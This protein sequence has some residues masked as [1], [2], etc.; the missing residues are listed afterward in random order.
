MRKI[1]LFAIVVVSLYSDWFNDIYREIFGVEDCSTMQSR[2]F[3]KSWQPFLENSEDAIKL[4]NQIDKTDIEDSWIPFIDT[5]ERLR[6]DFNSILDDIISILSQDTKV[7][8]CLKELQNINRKI[9]EEKEE[10]LRLKEKDISEVNQEIKEQV[11]EKFREIEALQKEMK[12]VRKS[13][14]AE[15]Q[16]LGLN[17]KPEELEAL[18]IRV[19]SF[20]IVQMLVVFD[21]SKKIVD[22]LGKLMESNSSN[23]RVI[24]RYYGMNLIVSEI[25][26][27]IQT[28][29]IEE[30]DRKYIPKLKKV[31]SRVEKL[32]SETKK[33]LK[34]SSSDYE[35]EI[36]QK[37]L[38]SQRL[39]IKTAKLYIEN[40]QSQRR[41]IEEAQK[42]SL[43]NLNL[44]RNSYR[45][46]EAGTALLNLI[47][48]SKENFNKIINLQIPKIIPFDNQAIAKEYQRLTDEIRK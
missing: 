2:N 19:D 8:E 6:R 5:K 12:I 23:M 31:I 7:I 11:A 1:F 33:L 22:R 20:N 24:K 25:A 28:K 26:Y 16:K 3:D 45:T 39:T 29:Y 44:T 40:L 27:Y 32:V 42:E 37:N 30:I 21:I 9:L 17:L 14:L 36:Y 34:N 41:Q 10:L 13:I 4:F 46:M 15:L 18:L 35:R 47:Q 48:V 38:E 43:K